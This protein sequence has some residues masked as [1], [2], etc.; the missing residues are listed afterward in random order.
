MASRSASCARSH[1]GSILLATP[2]FLRNY[3]RRCDKEEFA[4]LDVV[5][6]GAEKLPIDL[7][8]RLRG[9]VRRPAGRR[10]RNDGALPAGLREYSPEPFTGE[11]SNRLPRRFRR[12]SHPRR[13]RED[14]S[15][16]TGE[17]LGTNEDGM[18]WIRGP[19]VMK[20]YLH[21]PELTA[22]GPEGRLVHDRR[23]RSYRRGGLY[24]YHGF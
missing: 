22:E 20:G 13:Q 12:T 14:H 7:I 15:P 6:A 23:Y 8:E 19:N 16:E 17:E 10:L 21:Q 3:L 24:P 9:K 11:F 5:V 2:T 4:S 1:Q 18:L